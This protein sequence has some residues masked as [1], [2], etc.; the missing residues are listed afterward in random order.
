[1]TKGRTQKSQ[2][3]FSLQ[4]VKNILWAKWVVET[5][6][7]VTGNTTACCYHSAIDRIFLRGFSST[8]S[9]GQVE[10]TDVDFLFQPLHLKK[11]VHFGNK[12]KYRHHLN[13]HF[14]VTAF[15]NLD[16]NV[17]ISCFT[18]TPIFLSHWQTALDFCQLQRL[19]R[20]RAR[21]EKS[22]VPGLM[23]FFHTCTRAC[24]LDRTS[25]AQQTI[26]WQRTPW[27][28]EGA[29][30]AGFPSCATQI[31]V[32]QTA[33]TQI[34]AGWKQNIHLFIVGN[35][36][37]NFVCQEVIGFLYWGWNPPPRVFDWV[38]VCE[39]VWNVAPHHPPRGG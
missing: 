5:G 1:M 9:L 24:R 16:G 38:F 25:S 22:K 18:S 3:P 19:V 11:S 29:I 13:R 26:L 39:K 27:Q 10:L 30:S 12:G 21:N 31:E 2:V 15:M 4:P 14:H 23:L 28:G 36:C 34:S 7:G 8:R 6:A 37:Y 33:M 35:N 32:E 17:F 20:K